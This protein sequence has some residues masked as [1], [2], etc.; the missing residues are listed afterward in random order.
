M[1]TDSILLELRTE[2]VYRDMILDPYWFDFS[3]YPTDAA[4]YK[5]LN[6]SDD[7]IK[8]LMDANGKV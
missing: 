4:R 8:D 6:L 5:K 7:E 1:D 3:N 2:D